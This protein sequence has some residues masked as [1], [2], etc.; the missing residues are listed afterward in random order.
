MSV[1][2]RPRHSPCSRWIALLLGAAVVSAGGTT[3]AAEEDEAGR[4]LDRVL[5]VWAAR[6]P[7]AWRALWDFASPADAEAEEELVRN[8]F[9]ADRSM[10]EYLQR[11]QPLPEAP[12]MTADVRVF[13]T[14]KE[15]AR[16]AYWR[17]AGERRAGRWVLVRR[18][19]ES[20]VDGLVHLS[21]SGP[22]SHARNVSLRLKDF[23]LLMQDGTLYSSPE[24][25]GPTV[26][27]FVG[28]GRVRIRPGPAAEREQLRRFS[29][30]PHPDVAVRWAF[31]RIHPAQFESVLDASRLLPEPAPAARRVEAEKIF[32]ARSGRSFLLDNTLPGSPW[33][34]LPSFGD[35]IVDFPWS[36]KRV[37]TLAI[38]PSETEDVNLFD[39][40]RRMQICIYAS[41]GARAARGMSA[42]DVVDQELAVHFEPERLEL[43]AVQKLQVRLPYGASTLRLKLDEDLRVH[44]VATG[45][46]TSLLFFRVREQGTMVVSLGSLAQPERPFTLVIRYS[47]RHDPAP[48]QQE[49]VQLSPTTFRDE[50]QGMVERPPLVYSNY[51]AWYARVPDDDFAPTTASFDCPEGWM[52]VT[53]GT[54]LSIHTEARRTRTEFRLEQPGK[55]VTTVVGRLAEIGSRQQGAQAVRG[56][57]TTRLRGSVVQEMIRAERILQFY[58]DLFGPC[59]YPSLGLVLAEAALPAGHSPP[60]L[61]Y[62]EQ[63]P[64]MMR[65]HGLG[66]DPANFRDLPDFFLAHE[67]AHQWWGQGVAPASYRERWLSEA[68]AQYAAALWI[69]REQ[70]ESAF[71][72]MM[73]RMAR[74]AFRCDTAGPINLGQR[75]GALEGDSRILRAVV[76]DKGAWVLHM[77]RGIVGDEAFFRGVRRFLEEHRY[78]KV[79]TNDLREAFE[80][81]SGRDLGAY[82]ERWIYDTGLPSLEWAWRSEAQRGGFRTTL[83]A[84]AR[85][86]P[87]PLPLEFSVVTASGRLRR[88]VTVSSEGASWTV[89]TPELPRRV[90]PNEDRGLLARIK[91][92]GRVV[93]NPQR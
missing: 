26:L 10:I 25:L 17:L 6:D 63:Q 47:G 67:L 90:V 46:G 79:G 1:C 50:D 30:S 23:E 65:G 44:S 78:S 59:P 37:L 93:E 52:A 84:R 34:L 68:W 77:M 41:S 62:L 60:G 86:A 18:L 83:E 72:E 66:D 55:F 91:R 57:A 43:S 2:V 35:A 42:V 64:I 53:G 16:V 82:F 3:R 27:V 56:Y 20:A 85:S 54:L 80:E 8:A 32:A 39:R 28:Q 87:G 38:S 76:Y 22:V 19:Q 48:M 15:N 21:L 69:R 88:R 14:V 7:S 58:S 49:L 74:W 31:I 5:A 89:D 45:D 71:R 12:R 73:D 70:G 81:T 75:L 11:P 40:D 4:F 29:G 13:T 24:S 51:S 92:V 36:H 61:V 9:A 33:S